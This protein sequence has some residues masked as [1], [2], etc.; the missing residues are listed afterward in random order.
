MRL[1]RSLTGYNQVPLYTTTFG[2]NSSTS[3]YSVA[4]L[5]FTAGTVGVKQKRNN[6]R[7]RNLRAE[8]FE[9]R[10]YYGQRDISF[11]QLQTISSYAYHRVDSSCRSLNGRH[12]DV[13]DTRAQTSWKRIPLI[14]SLQSL[15]LVLFPV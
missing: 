13:S 6:A 12:H 10:V 14:A 2:A 4:L 3:Q 11:N 7:M 5:R 15:Y 8:W 9:E 1:N